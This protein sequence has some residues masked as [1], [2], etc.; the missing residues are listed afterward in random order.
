MTVEASQRDVVFT[1]F[2]ITVREV[3]AGR[4]AELRKPRLTA[5]DPA[6]VAVAVDEWFGLRARA[7]QVVAEANS[8][9]DDATERIVLDDEAGPDELAFVIRWQ[10][11][12]MRLHVREDGDDAGPLSVRVAV[13]RPGDG[14][15]V[16]PRDLGFLE[17]LVVDMVATG[18]KPAGP[19]A[20]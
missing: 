14:R 6:S 2:M 16:K 3:A 5:S 8:M 13:D 12:S 15:P 9:L 7:E 10:G 17:D 11:R 18:T 4:P 19:R 20:D 1:P